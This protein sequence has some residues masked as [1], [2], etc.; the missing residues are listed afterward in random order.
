MLSKDGDYALVDFQ[1][2]GG[3]IE[4]EIRIA[5]FMLSEDRLDRKSERRVALT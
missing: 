3:K 4:L 1:R 2:F 5:D